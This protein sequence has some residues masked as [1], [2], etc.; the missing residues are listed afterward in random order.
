MIR[1]KFARMVVVDLRP[2]VDGVPDGRT[3]RPG[4]R[5]LRPRGRLLQDLR[6]GERLD[7]TSTTPSRSRAATASWRSTPTRRRCATRAINMIFEGTNEILRVLVA[8]SGMR[9]VGE[10]LKEVGAGPEGPALLA[11]DPLGLRGAEDPRTSCPGGSTKVAPELAAG[12]RGRRPLRPGDRRR[13]G[14]AP[15]EVRKGRHPE[16]VPPGP[17]GQRGRSTSTRRSRC[18]PARRRRSRATGPQKAGEEIRLAKAFVRGREVPDGR[19]PQGD[20]QEP[21]RGTDGDLGDRLR[22]PRLRVPVLGVRRGA[23]SNPR[24]QEIEEPVPLLG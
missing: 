15:E 6:H 3:H 7:R 8:L 16:A 14:D 9:D 1:A 2:R 10:D 20:G 18:S 13:R 19:P 23:A 11:R 5:G 21:R 4:P 22:G 24:E 17:A 12:G